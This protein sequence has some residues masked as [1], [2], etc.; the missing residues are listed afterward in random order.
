MQSF[1]TTFPNDMTHKLQSVHNELQQALFQKQSPLLDDIN[2]FIHMA[3][4]MGMIEKSY[5]SFMMN[6]TKCMNINDVLNSHMGNNKVVVEVNDIY[7]MLIL[8]GL[9]VGFALMSFCAE[10]VSKVKGI[11]ASC[12]HI[13][14]CIFRSTFVRDF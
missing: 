8:L 2:I 12:H 6:A 4:Q 3:K 5:Y 9:G 1:H 11:L 13:L 14:K 7:G 10:F